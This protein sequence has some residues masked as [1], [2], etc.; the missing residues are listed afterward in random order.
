MI[1]AGTDIIDLLDKEKIS[2]QVSLTELIYILEVLERRTSIYT[3]DET[4]REE[5]C[6]RETTQLKKR[7]N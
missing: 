1:W 5:Q 2:F 6:G 4:L 3:Q 7:R